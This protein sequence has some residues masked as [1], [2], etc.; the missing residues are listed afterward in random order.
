MEGSFFAG[1]DSVEMQM[2]RSCPDL[3]EL[4]ILSARP[5]LEKTSAPPPPYA[6]AD[7]Q[8][9]HHDAVT[10]PTTLQCQPDI[11][12]SDTPARTVSLLFLNITRQIYEMTLSDQSCQA[13]TP[14]SVLINT[15]QRSFAL[16]PNFTQIS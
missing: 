11:Q 12:L 3:M 16:Y 5:P 15:G 10:R 4:F 9:M 7:A 8:Q 13:S 6:L 1:S 2:L 14:S